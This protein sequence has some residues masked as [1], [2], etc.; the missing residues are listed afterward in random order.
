[1]IDRFK[2]LFEGASLVLVN[3]SSM[4]N[5]LARNRNLTTEQI[6]I[7]YDHKKVNKDSLAEYP[8]LTDEQFTR[9]FNDTEVNKNNL[10][11]NPNLT[12]EQIDLLYQTK[13][14][15]KDFLAHYPKLTDKQFMRAFNDGKTDKEYLAHNPHLTTEQID[16]LYN[17]EDEHAVIKNT[18]AKIQKLTNEQF[19]RLFNHGD[20][21]KI[22]LSRNPHLTTEQIDLLYDT[23]VT[24]NLLAK[25]PK[26]TDE[27]FTRFFNNPDINKDYLAANPNLTPK[28]IDRL[29]SPYSAPKLYNEILARYSKLTDEQF[30]RFFNDPVVDK[31]KLARNPSINPETVADNYPT[32]VINWKW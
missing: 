9:F 8:K 21:S 18:F 22:Y 4:V 26:L 15:D 10:A 1:M 6:D 25:F 19:M 11:Q 2:M 28:Q 17:T 24:K 27:Q 3:E 16:L 5:N 13:G 30:T 31:N 23:G 20:V 29:Y 7:L 14:V 12:P 32:G